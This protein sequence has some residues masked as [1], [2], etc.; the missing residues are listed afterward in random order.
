MKYLGDNVY[1]V[2]PKQNSKNIGIRRSFGYDP[3]GKMWDRDRKITNYNFRRKIKSTG[4]I[5]VPGSK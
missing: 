4:G 5:Y 1:G 3:I 2:K